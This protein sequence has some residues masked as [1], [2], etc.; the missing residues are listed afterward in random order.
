MRFIKVILALACLLTGSLAAQEAKVTQVFSKD[1]TDLP[2][3]EGLMITVENA[4]DAGTNDNQFYAVKALPTNNVYAIGQ[5][6]GAA[7]PSH[8]LIE[9]WDRTSWKVVASPADASTALP[10]R[11]QS[12]LSANRRVSAF[13][14]RDAHL[15]VVFAVVLFPLRDRR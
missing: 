15:G 12:G 1:L 8:A 2:G 10:L 13:L 5:Q 3:K 6:A 7:F 4:V 11:V 9:D 14:K